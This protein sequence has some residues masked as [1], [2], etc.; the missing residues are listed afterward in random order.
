MNKPRSN[1]I[2]DPDLRDAGKRAADIINSYYSYVEWDDLKH[3]FVAISLADGS[4]DGTLYDSKKDAV[5]HQSFEQQYAYVGFRNLGPSG[6]SP[7]DL[8]VYL[9]VCRKAYN[10]GMRLVDPED[11][12]GGFD[13]AVSS[14]RFDATAPS[15][16]AQ[17]ATYTVADFDEIR[18]Q[19]G[20]R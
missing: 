20:L 15:V 6:A 11:Q 13:V 9:Q 2:P 17:I 19:L 12:Y 18:A 10:A 3:K 16:Y 5:R 1:V 4:S 7:R 14:A 8:S